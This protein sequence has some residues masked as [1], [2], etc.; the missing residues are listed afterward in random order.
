MHLLLPEPGPFTLAAAL[1]RP[2]SHSLI[3]NA[4]SE[5]PASMTAACHGREEAAASL[6]L[7]LMLASCCSAA[8]PGPQASAAHARQLQ[9]CYNAP[10]NATPTT[11]EDFLRNR[12]TSTATW[13]MRRCAARRRDGLL[14]H[15]IARPT[16]LD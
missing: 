2:W 5:G 9:E 10:Y 11:F 14:G 12:N 7:L 16:P 3:R 13:V 6:L 8:S 1:T 15:G 4:A